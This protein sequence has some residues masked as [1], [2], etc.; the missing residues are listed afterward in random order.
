[1]SRG[2]GNVQRAVLKI[3][4]ANADG[5]SADCLAAEIYDAPTAAQLES[6][7][8][9]IRGLR[10]S[11]LVDIESRWDRRE[12]SSLKRFIDLAPCMAPACALCARRRPRERIATGT[13]A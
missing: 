13:E 7:R 10:K 11:G 3:V 5:V 4:R 6:V 1:M 12:R 8:R 2:I 9:A